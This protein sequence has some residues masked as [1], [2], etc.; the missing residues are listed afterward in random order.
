MYFDFTNPQ[1]II[2]GSVLA[3][4]ITAASAIRIIVVVL[5]GY[6]HQSQRTTPFLFGSLANPSKP[7]SLGCM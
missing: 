7:Y 3:F 1:V 5:S 2:D 4:A 6:L